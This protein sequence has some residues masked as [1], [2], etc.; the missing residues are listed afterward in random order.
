MVQDSLLIRRLQDYYCQVFPTY[1]EA[2]LALESAALL[3]KAVDVDA[4]IV[5]VY[6]VAGEAAPV[7]A[8]WADA[9]REAR[10]HGPRM[11]AALLIAVPV[12]R[13]GCL[14]PPAVADLE[15]LL[16]ALREGENT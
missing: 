5:K 6:H 13:F 4:T 10:K 2:R 8:F 9:F 16:R 7:A 3:R 11:L 14:G 12:E 15:S 1:S